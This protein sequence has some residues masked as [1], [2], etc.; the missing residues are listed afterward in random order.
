M[1]A[2]AIGWLVTRER[3]STLHRPDWRSETLARKELW[4]STLTEATLAEA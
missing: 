1:L 3:S 4:N 2:A